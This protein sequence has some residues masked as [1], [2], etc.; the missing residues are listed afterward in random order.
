MEDNYDFSVLK[1]K[2]KVNSR[3]KGS[4]FERSIAKMFNDRFKT[5]EFSRTPGSGAFATTH[6]LPDYLKIYGDLITPMNF[7]YCIECKKGYNKEN[8]YSL[9]NY[10]SDFW[11]FVDQ[12]EKDSEKCQKIPMVIFKQDRQKTLAIVPYNIIYKS[13]NYIEIHKEE[14]RYKIYLFDDLLKEDDYLWLD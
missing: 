3:A 4:T 12:C 10:S 2:K 1:K 6:T 11:K 9:Y 7:K 14:K 5:A 13:N 8:L